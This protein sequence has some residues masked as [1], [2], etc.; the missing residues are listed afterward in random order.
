MVELT[1]TRG[2]MVVTSEKS[3]LVTPGTLVT[4]HAAR[5]KKR[6]KHCISQKI[7][8]IKSRLIFYYKWDVCYGPSDLAPS[9]ISNERLYMINSRHGLLLLITK[10]HGLVGSCLIV[11]LHAVIGVTTRNPNASQPPRVSQGSL[12]GVNE[13]F[14]VSTFPQFY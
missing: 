13:L 10:V 9:Q 3:V 1:A 2:K 14:M 5:K 6:N 4:V 11:I 7:I 8:F 12:D